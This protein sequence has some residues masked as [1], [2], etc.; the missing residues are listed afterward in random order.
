MNEKVKLTAFSKGAGCGCKL[1]PNILQELKSK[2]N[3]S[4]NSPKLLVG[5][6]SNDDAAAFAIENDNAIISTTD[7]FTPIV[8]DPYDF[9][10]IAAANAISDIYAMGGS[11]IMGLAILGWP[12]ENL[13]IEIANLVMDGAHAVCKEAGIHLAG[14]HSINSLEPI[15]GLAVTGIAKQENI[16]KNNTARP[17]CKLFLTKPIGVGLITTAHK[18]SLVNQRDFSEALEVM[19]KLN[20]IG[21][22]LGNLSAVSSMTDVTGFGLIGHLIEMCEGSDVSAKVERR[23]VPRLS[24]CEKY[25]SLD[26]VPGGTFR[27]YESYRSKVSG[28][29]DE[30]KALFFDPQTSGGLLVAVDQTKLNE[31]HQLTDN[32]KLESFGEITP[33]DNNVITII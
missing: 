21:K 18:K 13:S 2:L 11:P 33:K 30:E 5:N 10:R 23:K 24:N 3:K 27:N 32:L 15:F 8:D 7:F 14:G 22:S 31:F 16:K 26:C 25:I 28:L 9:G 1:A 4:N 6:E 19:T 12:I 17:G 29:K 20:D